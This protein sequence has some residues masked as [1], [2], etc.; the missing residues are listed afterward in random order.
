MRRLLVT[1]DPSSWPIP[2]RHVEIV[3]ARDYLTEAKAWADGGV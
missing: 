1:D 2:T 3:H